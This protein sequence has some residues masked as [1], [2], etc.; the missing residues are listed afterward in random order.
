MGSAVKSRVVYLLGAGAS[1]DAGIPLAR[2]LTQIAL[3]QLNNSA[4]AWRDK[5]ETAALNFVVAMMVA[6]RSRSGGG[7][8]QFPDI[9][10][11]V[12]A[13]ELLA[14]RDDLEVSPFIQNWDPSV[15]AFDVQRLA[16][17]R[18][19][20]LTRVLKDGH[21]DTAFADELRRFIQDL[22]PR[23]GNGDT[24]SRLQT[25]LIGLLRQ[26]LEIKD[27]RQCDYLQ[28]L[29]NLGRTEEVTIATLNYDLGIELVAGDLDV[30]ISL[31][32]ESWNETWRLTWLGQ[33]I[34]LIKLHGSINWERTEIFTRNLVGLGFRNAGVNIVDLNSASGTPFVVYGRREKLRPEGPFLELRAKFE[35]DLKDSTHLVVI[36]YS[37]ADDHVNQLIRSWLAMDESRRLFVVDPNFPEDFQIKAPDFA[38][39]LLRNLRHGEHI[40]G[41]YQ[42]RA[43]R[44]FVLRESA[45]TG[46]AKLCGG[47]REL[48][49]LLESTI[50]RRP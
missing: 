5:N 25:T 16:P 15:D 13:V 23:S 39:E 20:N 33:G 11:V 31:G 44:L 8:D 21:V 40:E 19:F 35:N 18:R 42:I 48:D 6:H 22:A 37:F 34:N 29:V 1:V 32:I 17:G 30:P 27:I 9:E 3:K 24:Y 28:Q 49:A 36:G 12:S 2:E 45:E 41:T 4:T 43:T 46:I 26:S 50:T 47:V 14:T 10:A 7:A 38:A